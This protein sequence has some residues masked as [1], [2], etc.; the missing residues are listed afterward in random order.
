M[1]KAIGLLVSLFFCAHLS[2]D[3]VGEKASYKINNDR[4]SWLIKRG[5]GTATVEQF[6][7]DEVRGP[8]YLVKIAYEFVVR[9]HGTEK[10]EIGLLVPES[11]LTDEFL[12]NIAATHPQ[13][14]D[15]FS[16]DYVG[17]ADAVDA[18]GNEYAECTEVLLYDIDTNAYV[19]PNPEEEMA[20]LWHVRESANVE[21]ENLEIKVKIHK[22]IP[23]VGAVTLDVSG[24]ARGLDFEAGF[25]F[26]PEEAP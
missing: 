19:L 9:F 10:G 23:V 6:I 2:A 17:L 14:Y 18:E 4:S 5:N 13:V 26:V 15:G 1:K 21:V 11:M 12:D 20:V 22:S 25:D 8:S 7:E 24:I 3:Y 16:I